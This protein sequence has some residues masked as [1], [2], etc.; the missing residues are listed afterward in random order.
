M[1]GG[2]SYGTQTCTV[3]SRQGTN[4]ERQP[5]TGTIC[6]PGLGGHTALRW[7]ALVCFLIALV[8]SAWAQRNYDFVISGARIVDGTGA[9]WFEGDIAIA[10]DRIAAMGKLHGTA[11][12]RR[13]DAR[14]L[15]VSPGFIDVQG[16][17]EFNLLVDGRAASKITQGVTSEI[18]GEGVSIAPLNQRVLED[19]RNRAK[20]YGVQ[21]DWR[22]LDE[23]LRHLERSKPAINLGTF[24]GAGGLRTYVI[25][26]DN[27]PATATE[28][29]QMRRL[30]DESMRQGAF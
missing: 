29:D 26:K 4:L 27:R 23:Y 24:I 6:R 18:T 13:I 20:K 11:A 15:V 19:M 3:S 10:G 25:G 30:L 14:G 21:L 2:N 1:W 7:L 8:S 28:L 5:M 9:P 22:S 17:S 16:Q 12:K